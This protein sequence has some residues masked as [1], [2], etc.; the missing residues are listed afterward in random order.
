[1]KDPFFIRVSV[2]GFTIEFPEEEKL[3]K[4]LDIKIK[5][6][7]ETNV[8]YPLLNP[9]SYTKI[10]W[11]KEENTVIYEIN[12]IKLNEQEQEIL[13]LAILEI[14]E[15]LEENYHEISDLEKKIEYLMNNFDYFLSINNIILPQNSYYKIFY[16]LYKYFIGYGKIEPLI[17]DPLIEDISCDGIRV[18][19][20][21]LHKRFGTIPTNVFYNNE[22][23]LQEEIEK[24]AQRSGR[25]VSYSKPILDASLPEGHR[26]N[27]TYSS[28][29]T[30]KGPTFTIRKFNQIPLT[31]VD[32]IRFGS[33]NEVLM[34]IL[35]LGVQ[36]RRNFLIIGETASGKT[37]LLNTIALFIPKTS[38][39]VSI[40]DTRE[41]N[42]PFENWIPS[43]SRTGVGI[44]KI[45]EVTLFDLL[46][47]SLRQNPDY[48]IVGEVRGKEANILFQ[49][50]ASGHSSFATF[51]AN[52]VESVIARLT[53]PP[54]N[55][56]A[57]LISLLDFVILTIKHK[58]KRIVK[59]VYEIYRENNEIK[60][61]VLIE[62]DFQTKRFLIK[63]PSKIFEKIE[64]F[65]GITIKDLWK[66]V[67]TRSL[68]LAKLKET[69]IDWKKFNDLVHLYYINKEKVLK[70]LKIPV[71]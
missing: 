3:K 13:E 59:A 12:E 44:N 67:K 11:N 27:A 15:L 42:L 36:Y 65:Y 38:K 31:P 17:R 37:T 60:N 21:I 19:I 16:F 18:P 40:E 7:E 43:V 62:Y 54:I 9:F 50:M 24:L 8:V 71:F 20:Y 2:R 30:T 23:E 33:V 46:K 66:E 28:D 68:V 61:Q 58:N 63:N 70:L 6:I 34:S 4:L 45:G 5:S 25:Y 57:S 10:Y 49:G 32:L 48:L 53:T 41:L 35:W 26:V 14:K 22:E 56:P 1:L 69:N 51:H 29:I 55:L 47:A 39:I 52:S 64:N